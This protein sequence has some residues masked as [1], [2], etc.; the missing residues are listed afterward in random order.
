MTFALFHFLRGNVKLNFSADMLL[1]EILVLGRNRF[2]N[3]EAT[4]FS[5]MAIAK[6]MHAEF[7]YHLI[8]RIIK[9]TELYNTVVV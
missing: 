7:F 6:F 9:D 3:F 8:M 5:N 4:R 1:Y 2:H